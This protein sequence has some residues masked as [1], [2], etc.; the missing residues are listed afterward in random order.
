[1]GS[2]SKRFSKVV[3]IDGPSGSGKSTMAKRLSADL[4][5]LYVDTG[6]MY[7][8]V[9]LDLYEK[10]IDFEDEK[11]V[12]HALKDLNMVYGTR[13]DELIFL[14]GKNRTHDIRQHFVSELASKVSQKLSVRKAMVN[15]QRELAQGQICVME[16]R[17]VGTVVFPDAFI[18][19][20]LDADD[21][22]RAKRRFDELVEQGRT[23]PQLE[24]LHQDMVER[25]R[26]DK[27]RRW[28]PLLKAKEAITIDS[29]QKTMD[30]ILET[31]KGHIRAK[32]LHWG[33]EL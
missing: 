27:G 31:M 16:G 12:S 30:E 14:N 23:P 29:G 5:F 1:M 17:D 18:K 9:A 3:A 7:R 4:G 22:V 8:G 33:I 28:A 25:D 24:R 19:F 21:R 15:W 20:F 6:A 13:E 32:A 11:Q 2:A 10:G 26:E